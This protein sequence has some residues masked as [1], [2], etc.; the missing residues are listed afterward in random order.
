MKIKIGVL[1]KKKFIKGEW[2]L[3]DL[4]VRKHDCKKCTKDSWCDYK[5]YQ[6]KFESDV[7]EQFKDKDTTIFEISCAFYKEA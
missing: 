5:K 6:D 2:K 3:S 1:S 7:E 4:V